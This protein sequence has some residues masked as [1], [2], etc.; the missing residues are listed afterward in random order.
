MLEERKEIASVMQ[1]CL[2]EIRIIQTD[3]SQS[4][5]S[6]Q[7]DIEKTISEAIKVIN[8]SETNT[9]ED[10]IVAKCCLC[11]LLSKTRTNRQEYF[12]NLDE[13]NS[14]FSSD[15][16][17][18]SIVSIS[19]L[20]LIIN[21]NFRSHYYETTLVYIKKAIEYEKQFNTPLTM[22]NKLEIR[23]RFRRR[24]LAALCYE[25]IGLEKQHNMQGQQGIEDLKMAISLLVGSQLIKKYQESFDPQ[26]V[27]KRTN[28]IYNNCS[29]LLSLPEMSDDANID[30][31]KVGWNDPCLL[32]QVNKWFHNDGHT[33]PIADDNS[34]FIPP[35]F[36][37]LQTEFLAN[38][39]HSL[40]HC[41][42][43]YVKYNKEGRPLDE[44]D[45]FYLMISE[46]LINNLGPKYATCHAILLVERKE[47]YKALML[48][49]DTKNKLIKRFQTDCPSMNEASICP[50]CGINPCE[51]KN[52]YNEIALIDF[53][54]WYF[55]VISKSGAEDSESNKEAFKIY[56]DKTHDPVALTYYNVINLKGLLIDGFHSISHGISVTPSL[57]KESKDEI[58][59]AY[60]DL[61]NSPP[62]STIH[63]AIWKEWDLLHVAYN[64][65]CLWCNY[66]VSNNETALFCYRLQR[67]LLTSSIIRDIVP[68]MVLPSK[69][70]IDKP[71]FYHVKTEFGS[72]IYRG[73]QDYL[74]KILREY[75]TKSVFLPMLVEKLKTFL[76]STSTREISNVLLVLGDEQAEQDIEFLTTII[77][78]NND[79]CIE[80]D[81][82][83]VFIDAGGV[84]ES[85]FDNFLSQKGYSNLN[86][87]D[88][89]NITVL[90]DRNLACQL[91]ITFSS[92]EKL[93]CN[94]QSPLVSNLISPIS[95]DQTYVDQIGSLSFDSSIL[96]LGEKKDA[97]QMRPVQQLQSANNV[98][99]SCLTTKTHS[100]NSGRSLDLSYL[101]ECLNRNDYNRLSHMFVFQIDNNEIKVDSFNINSYRSD[102]SCMRIYSDTITNSK[103]DDIIRALDNI[104]KRVTSERCSL[105]GRRYHEYMTECCSD[106]C[107]SLFAKMTVSNDTNYKTIREYLLAFLGTQ[108]S[109]K[110]NV[111]F[112]RYDYIARHYKYILFLLD[113]SAKDNRF[114]IELCNMIQKYTAF[115]Q[116]ISAPIPLSSYKR[117]IDYKESISKVTPGKKY[118]F[119]SYRSNDNDPKLVYP[120]FD[121]VLS[122]QELLKKNYNGEIEVYLDF[123]NLADTKIRDGIDAVI[124][125]PNCIGAIIYTTMEY[126]LPYT[127]DGHSLKPETNDYCISELKILNN[128]EQGDKKDN[129]K[130]ENQKFVTFP[131]F[132]E[133]PQYTNSGCAGHSFQSFYK[134]TVT[135]VLR[136]HNNNTRLEY[137]NTLF[138]CDQSDNIDK[139]ILSREPNGSHFQNSTHL[140]QFIVKILKKDAVDCP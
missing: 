92:L 28:G 38:I 62:D 45:H 123:V 114:S 66:V 74:E 10:Y 50:E 110:S 17:K 121:D 2:E 18:E 96:K 52:Y 31:E 139:F 25:Y 43:E 130:P 46:M 126:L 36:A 11:H 105:A 34:Q 72:F 90:N 136:E 84:E 26:E 27:V 132:F 4:F 44:L 63:S 86:S 107:K 82:H 108:I 137:Y 124:S 99:I 47:Y 41:L 131:V 127:Q 56:C 128:R 81:K 97:N 57:L 15:Y 30:C 1:K 7:E 91:C 134:E 33:S 24:W 83:S 73:K 80:D 6:S 13:L 122:L 104:R 111:L 95:E 3:N 67:L 16:Y 19:L 12:H 20:D 5:E 117:V 77:D 39:S 78:I 37:E 64:A 35:E 22:T 48:L 118:I 70:Y 119:V 69:D 94:L 65:F 138:Q 113:D 116:E 21:L 75:H 109:D 40:A 9:I 29:N 49:R 129:N 106:H 102:P 14:V 59:K 8:A 125:D 115:F 85:V 32:V 54:I 93:L 55:S 58:D 103:G 61:E 87:L 112:Q 79:T 53:Y 133:T 89:N 42:S 60:R 101:R 140:N 98:V 71:C 120:V 88:Q 68:D 76:T 51:F 23:S 100:V 135:K